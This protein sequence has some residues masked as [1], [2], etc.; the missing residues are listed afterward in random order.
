VKTS[1]AKQSTLLRVLAFASCV[2]LMTQQ[3][4]QNWFL[5]GTL[6]GAWLVLRVVSGARRQPVLAAS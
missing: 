1:T 4:A 6:M 3:S 5:A 2:V